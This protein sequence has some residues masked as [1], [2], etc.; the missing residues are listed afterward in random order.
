MSEERLP[1]VSHRRPISMLDRACSE[2]E[3][4]DFDRE[5]RRALGEDTPFQYTVEPKMEGISVVMV[6]QSGALL[7]AATRGDGREGALITHNLK[8]ILTVPLTLEVLGDGKPF[9]DLLEVWGDVYME[10]QAFEALN[11]DRLAAHLPVF[12]D[13]RAAAIDSLCQPDPRVTAKR[14]LNMFCCGVGEMSGLREDTHYGLMVTIQ[15][16]GLRVNRPHIQVCATIREVM[17]RCRELEKTRAQSPYEVGGAV[18]QLNQLDL[19]AGLAE[20]SGLPRWAI[21]YEFGPA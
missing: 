3:I 14:R 8:T 2:Q 19:R 13:P 11:R 12:A 5:I 17:E 1:K 4:F 21:A 9:P 7:T 16:W 20:R 18:I 6:Y 15:S 10:V